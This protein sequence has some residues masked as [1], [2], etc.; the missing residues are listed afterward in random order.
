MGGG[1][2]IYGIDFSGAKDAGNKIWI[3]KCVPVGESLLIKECFRAR[4]LPNSGKRVETCLPAL[5]ELIKSNQ[6]AVFGFDFPFGLPA[7]LVKEMTWEQFVLAFPKKYKSPEAFRGA[8]RQAKKGG[9]LKRQTD[10]ES[11]T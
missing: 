3:A 9:E 2:A 5:V 6:N 1:R 4:D 10:R 11:H 8:C 7:P